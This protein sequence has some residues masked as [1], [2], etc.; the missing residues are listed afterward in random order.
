[1]PVN[2]FKDTILVEAIILILILFI[3]IIYSKQIKNLGI[4]KLATIAIL[5][6]LAAAGGAALRSIPGVQPTSFII[7][8]CGA[9]FGGGAGFL[10]GVVAALLFDLLSVFSV[11][12]LW[13]ILLWGIMGLVAAYIPSKKPLFLAIYG[14]VWGYVFGWV[15]NSVY[16]IKGFMPFSVE[17]FIFSCVTSF[18][19]DFLHGITNAVLLLVFSKGTF[20]LLQ[21]AN[22]N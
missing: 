14:F 9:L 15:L 8:S 1:V 16:F 11:F 10:C 17:A 5:C 13:R 12:T 4:K 6:A 21:K 20:L 22:K 18:W 19:F 7:I 2:L 3:L